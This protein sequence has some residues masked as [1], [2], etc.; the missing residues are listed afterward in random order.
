VDEPLEVV[1]RRVELAELARFVDPATTGLAALA[2]KGPAGMGKTALWRQGLRMARERGWAVLAARPTGAEVSLSFSGLADLFAAVQGETLDRLPAVQRHALEVALLR[3]EAGESAIDA[4]TVSTGVLSA[5]REMSSRDHVLVAIDD[6]Q[7]LD[8]ATASAL[9]FALRRLD[10]DG[11]RLL[12]TLRDEDGLPKTVVGAVAADRRA[13]VTLVPLDQATTKEILRS[14]F[15]SDLAP[16]ATAKVAQ[17]SGGNPFYAIEIAREVVRLGEIPASGAVPVPGELRDLIDARVNRLPS[18]TQDALLAASCLSNPRTGLVDARALGPAEQAGLVVLERD[19]RIRFTHPLLAAAVYEPAPARRRR[20]VHRMLAGRIDDPEE[21]ARHLALGSEGPD[22]EIAA[23]LDAAAKLAQ[24]R[25]SPTAAA[26]LIELA[27]QLAPPADGPGR[28]ERLVTGAG[29][30]FEAGDLRRAQEM[31]EEALGM[32]PGG[33]LRASALRLLA[34]LRSRRAGFGEAVELASEAVEAAGDEL[35]L[36][37][38]LHLDLVFYRTS[39]GDFAG[40]LPHADAALADAETFGLDAVEAQALAVRTMIRFLCGRGLSSPDLARA[41][42]LE[43]P[44]FPAPI[45]MRPRTVAG[46]IK[47]WTDRPSEALQIL[48]Q[49]RADATEQGRE[50]DVP[51]LYFY[52]VWACLWRGDV[53]GAQALAIESRRTAAQLEDRIAN[54]LAYAAGALA[55]AYAGDE[56]AVRTDAEQASA[57]FDQMGWHTGSIWSSWALG[58][59]ELSLGHNAAVDAVLAPLSGLLGDMSSA[60]P[61]L[62]VFLP[63]HIEALI[64]LGR[65]DRARELLDGFERQARAVGRTWALA[66]AARCR[67]LLSA[68]LGDTDGALAALE[69][70]LRRHEQLELPFERARSLLELGCLQRRRKQKRLA[71]ELLQEAFDAFSSIGA[72]IWAERSQVELR[73]VIGRQAPAGLTATEE[74]IARLAVEGLTNRAIAQRS[75]VTVKTVEANLAR[76]YRKLRITSRAQLGRALDRQEDHPVA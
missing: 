65:L 45:I 56:I 36:R 9:G 12:A 69:D 64:K 67:G 6:A 8:R 30:Y 75:F 47:L 17:A 3:S 70:A 25:G 58:L 33:P 49:Q 41:L 76:A 7:W 22:L 29:L 14:R 2:L 37:A 35:W 24:A 23:L 53:A 52:L 13:E 18:R 71:R 10:D 42:E 32:A 19:G 62:G 39:L 63:D 72:P 73:R 48:Q 50:S 31:L 57:L 60:D 11:V 4:R 68:A 34:H 20:A 55:G 16:R 28:A 27:L 1:G 66:L 59:L 51:L 5:L 46:L 54:A 44:L 38:A 74:A 61:V 21:R 40:A 43:D 26:E 15:Q